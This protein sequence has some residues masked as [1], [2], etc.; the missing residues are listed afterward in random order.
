MRHCPCCRPRPP[1]GSAACSTSVRDAAS[2][3]CTRTRTPI[4]SPQ[5]TSINA[6]S[7]S[8]QQPWP[9]TDW[10]SN[11]F[12][13]LVRTRRGRTFDQVVANPPFVVGEARVHHTYRD[14]GLDLD[15][16]SELMISQS[17]D[18]LNPG[19]TA[20]LLASWVHV[21]GQDW[22][23]RIASWLP[24]HGVDAWVVQRDVAD[25]ALYVA[26]GSRTAGR[27]L[28]IRKRHRE[29]TPGWITSKKPTSRA[30]ASV[31]C[32]FAAPTP[33]PT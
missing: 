33:P 16:A 27:I 13:V 32:S 17:I 7:T 4:R 23:S 10:T 25:P 26:R 30:S 11:S 24:A 15:G 22:R 6:L 19:G 28:E 20:A 5:P 8:R 3:P 1:R 31:S 29:Q 9:S 18:Y 21:E 12:K 14:S 2:K